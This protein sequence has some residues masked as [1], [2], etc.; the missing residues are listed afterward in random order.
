MDIQQQKS[1][2]VL[3]VG[4]ACLD[5][6]HYGTCERMSPEAPVPVFKKEREEIRFGMSHNVKLNLESFGLQVT[7]YHNSEKIVKH[8]FIEDKYKQQIFRCDEGESITLTPMVIEI[9][10]QYDAIVVSDYNKGF[11]TDKAFYNFLQQIDSS[12]PV[13]V[14]SKK[15][16]LSI[17]KNCYVKINEHE[18]KKADLSHIQEENLIVTLGGKGA[19]WNGE[20]Y[21]TKQVDVYDVCGAGDVFLSALVFGYLKFGTM[22]RAIPIANKC[23]AFSVTKNGTY[24]L[25]KENINDLCF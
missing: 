8:R 21:P 16:D 9:K 6:Y 20:V 11:V 12:T 13:F 15:Q 22:E 17:F 18:H 1:F 14:D 19:I 2:K 7:H 23:A 5:M 4:D 10:E 3:L 24:V 25:T